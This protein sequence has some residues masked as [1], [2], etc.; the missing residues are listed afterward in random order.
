MYDWENTLMNKDIYF[1]KF[2]SSSD[3]YMREINCTIKWRVD[4]DTEG[5]RKF[6]TKIFILDSVNRVIIHFYF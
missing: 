5:Y 2:L 1:H 6:A 3:T 4:L